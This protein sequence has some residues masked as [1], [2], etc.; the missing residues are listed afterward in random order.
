[1]GSQHQHNYLQAAL[2][3]EPQDN[4]SS[5]YA[6][7]DLSKTINFFNN[8]YET[9]KT[10]TPVPSISNGSMKYYNISSRVNN[11]YTDNY[12]K[13][14]ST[15]NDLLNKEKAWYENNTGRVQEEDEYIL[16]DVQELLESVPFF[17]FMYLFMEHTVM[18]D[19]VYV[20]EKEDTS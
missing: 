12:E 9:L 11:L 15:W 8:Y 4:S 5:L 1:M 3:E 16:D 20:E 14:E 17:D 10:K 2:F 13:F 6:S 19:K 7:D 18:K